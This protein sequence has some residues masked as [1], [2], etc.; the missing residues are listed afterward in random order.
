MIIRSKNLER[1]LECRIFRNGSIIVASRIY[2][3]QDLVLGTKNQNKLITM[4]D[5]IIKKQN[6]NKSHW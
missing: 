4:A 2:Q 6:I 3:L 5:K 1:F